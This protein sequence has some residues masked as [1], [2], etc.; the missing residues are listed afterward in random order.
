[1]AYIA[2]QSHGC[3]IV[4]ATV[5]VMGCEPKVVRVGLTESEAR[6]EA[7]RLTAAE[8][9]ARN[10][11]PRWCESTLDYAR[12]LDPSIRM[13]RCIGEHVM[14]LAHRERNHGESR[15]SYLGEVMAHIYGPDYI[16]RAEATGMM[17]AIRA[18]TEAWRAAEYEAD[19]HDEM[20]LSGCSYEEAEREI[21]F[22]R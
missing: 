6:G 12:A 22:R 20:Y 18:T 1:M 2:E 5:G 3:W 19:I 16:A 17:P 10:D 8:R 11:L 7:E 9:R 13:L 15:D 14:G 21:S 4:R